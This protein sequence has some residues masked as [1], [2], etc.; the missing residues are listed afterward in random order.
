MEDQAM[1]Y[2]TTLAVLLIVVDALHA[3]GSS[4]TR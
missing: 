1:L 4:V 2:F 3:I